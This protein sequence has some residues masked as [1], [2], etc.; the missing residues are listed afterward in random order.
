MM[1]FELEYINIYEQLRVGTMQMDIGGGV[2]APL[3]ANL[4]RKLLPNWI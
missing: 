3:G 1:Y 2:G 4:W